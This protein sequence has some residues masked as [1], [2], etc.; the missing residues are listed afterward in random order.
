MPPSIEY[1]LA[2]G[3]Q[4]EFWVTLTVRVSSLYQVAGPGVTSTTDPLSIV[5]P[6]EAGA[7]LSNWI[8]TAVVAAEATPEFDRVRNRTVCTKSSLTV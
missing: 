5:T 3:A 6:A 4:P 1:W 2:T 8:V 7:V